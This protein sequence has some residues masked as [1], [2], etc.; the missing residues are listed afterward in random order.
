MPV[1]VKHIALISI[2]LLFA[3]IT[4]HSKSCYVYIPHDMTFADVS[5]VEAFLKDEVYD[6]SCDT[7]E[8]NGSIEMDCSTNPIALNFNGFYVDKVSK[9]KGLIISNCPSVKSIDGFNNI[10]TIGV[11]TCL[12]YTSPSPRDQRGSRMPSSA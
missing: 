11:L 8:I 12:L 5:D 6:L 1:T 10:D 4:A 7:I 2:L 3:K 9:V